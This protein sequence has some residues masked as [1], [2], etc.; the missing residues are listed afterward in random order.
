MLT[1]DTTVFNEKSLMA[2]HRLPQ[3][4]QKF[5]CKGSI[6]ERFVTA[7]FY[8]ELNTFKGSIR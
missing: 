3:T 4:M 2:K 7:Y 6:T 8:T 1:S 5:C